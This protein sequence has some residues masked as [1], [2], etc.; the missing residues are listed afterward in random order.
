[1]SDDQK[2]IGSINIEFILMLG[3]DPKEAVEYLEN[4]RAV[5]MNPVHIK[6]HQILKQQPVASS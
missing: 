4:K 5:D 6:A 2:V 1:M 3:L